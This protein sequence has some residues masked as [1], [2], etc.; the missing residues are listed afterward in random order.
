MAGPSYILDKT[1]TATTAVT[2]YA[3]VVPYATDGSADGQCKLPAAGN[4]AI[5]GV[6]QEAQAN[7]GENVTVRVAGITRAIA[8]STIHAGDYVRVVTTTGYFEAV[9]LSTSGG[10]MNYVC[11]KAES[12]AT[13]QGQVFFLRLGEFAAE[14]GS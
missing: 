7:A 3:A 13:A 2:K 11:G 1:Y 6:A 10:T 14:G 12:S 4:V 8:N 5:L 9:S